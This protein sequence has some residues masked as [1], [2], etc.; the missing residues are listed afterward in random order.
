MHRCLRSTVSRLIV[1]GTVA[2]SGPGALAQGVT[3]AAL[4]GT[5]RDPDGNAV[6]DAKVQLVNPSTGEVFNTVTGANGQYF[7]DNV[8]SGGPYKLAATAEGYQVSTREAIQLTLG[9]RLG[10]DL[11]LKYA[12]EEMEIVSHLDAL[13]DRART[14]ASTTLKE[15]TIKRL[16]LQGRNFTNLVTTDSRV[17]STGGG[18]S[19]AGQNNRL[20]NIQIDGGANNDLFGLADNG[21]PGGT[22]GAKPLSIEA[23]KEFNVQIAPFDVRLGNFVG[24]LVNAVTK[25]GTNDLHGTV[26]GYYQSRDLANKK[27]F[28]GGQYVNDTTFSGYTV[29]QFGAAVGGPIIRDKAHFFISADIQQRQ[30]SLASARNLTG[31]DATDILPSRAGFTVATAERFRTLLG[32][33]GITAGSATSS[34][35]SNP[36]RNIFVKVTANPFA[37]SRLELSYNFVKASTDVLIRNPTAPSLP[38]ATGTGVVTSQ[39]N[40]RDGYEIANAGYS[41]ANNTN[42]VRGKLSSNFNDGKVS[43]EL[44]AGV[45]IIRDERTLQSNAPLILVRAAPRAT[46]P[47]TNPGQNAWLAAGAERFS[48]ANQLDQDVYQLQDN[49]SFAL[50]THRMVVGT[51]NEYLKIRNLFLQAKTG[52][53]AFDCLNA[54]DC[55]NSLEAGKPVAFQ[56]R[57]GAS[58][59]QEPGTAKFNATQ[60]GLYVQDEWAAVRGLTLTPGVRM[61]LP[62]LPKGVQNTVVLNS[63]TLP[64]D[65]SQIPSGNI[66]WSPRLGFNWDVDGSANTVVRGGIGVFSGRPAYVWVSNAYTIN[67]LS[68]V[69]LTC[70]GAT[71]VPTF[72][73]DPNAQPSDCKGGTGTPIAP[74][75]QGEIDYFDPNTKYPQN[76][77]YALG[78]DRRL[79]FGIVAGLDLMY[80]QDINGWYVTDENLAPTGTSGEG[81]T[82]Y[83]AFNAT[84]F[85]TPAGGQRIAPVPNRLDNTNLTNAIK[86][87]NKN[88]GKVYTASLQL[89]KAFGQDYSLN[90]GYTFSRSYDLIS[91]TSSQALSNFQFEAIDGD[92]QNRNARPSAF[93]RPHRFTVA[94]SANLPYGFGVGLTYIFQSGTPYTWVVNGDVNGDGQAGNDAVFVPRLITAADG[95]QTVDQTQITLANT[96]QSA[97]MADFINNQSCLR[98]AQGTLL[99]RGACRNPW[100]GIVDMRI[101]WT[102]PPIKWDQRIEVQWDIFNVMNLLNRSWGLSEQAAQFSTISGGSSFL[103]PTGYDVANNRPRYTFAP[104]PSVVTTVYGPTSSRWRM[105]LGARY[106]F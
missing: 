91:L 10:A 69:Q 13:D 18:P 26:F 34:D 93:D 12:G 84:T 38:T 103:N 32:N 52:V 76:L 1:L 50:G 78:V 51:T 33:Y 86:I 25:S 94:G 101:T 54:A 77:R 11:A 23:I 31:D 20:N 89:Q 64:I 14:G 4:T 17:S 57:F 47:A 35:L 63:P 68:Q 15:E 48:H 44:L 61:D 70:V 7:L 81:R 98:E 53:W 3:G 73:A 92:I 104:Q 41:N 45:S 16:P 82:A 58:T 37:N 30:F 67:G 43:N 79:P 27:A 24:G 83:G 65:T 21:T 90:L 71:G 97:A 62:I 96:T 9:Q 2:L 49:V 46:P 85:T 66:L 88:G 75:N 56:R 106:I 105:Q 80:T 87:S 5:I 74:T 42:T 59:L 40:L 72:T 22:A 100:G 55:P 29:G 99:K 36:D 6:P 102:S 19:F 39:G 28:I 60:L 95:S 8:P